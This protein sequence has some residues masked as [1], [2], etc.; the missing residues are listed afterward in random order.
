VASRSAPDRD[1]R[2]LLAQREDLLTALRVA[3]EQIRLTGSVR[4]K[5][6]LQ[7]SRRRPFWIDWRTWHCVDSAAPGLLYD[8]RDPAM[9]GILHRIIPLF[10]QRI[11]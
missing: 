2:R 3:K 9:R 4:S 10:L 11:G 7:L 5:A 6:C 1:V 8:S